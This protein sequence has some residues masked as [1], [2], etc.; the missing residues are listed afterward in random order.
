MRKR[1]KEKDTG[2]WHLEYDIQMI[3]SKC[4]GTVKIYP[5]QLILPQ[6]QYYRLIHRMILLNMFIFGIVAGRFVFQIINEQMKY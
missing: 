3:I 4:I 6:E 1:E 2:I 5:N